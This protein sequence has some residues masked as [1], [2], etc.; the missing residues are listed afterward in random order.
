MDPFVW[1]GRALSSVEVFYDADHPSVYVHTRDP[2]VQ[3]SSV[4]NATQVLLLPSTQKVQGFTNLGSVTSGGGY[5]I[6]QPTMPAAISD[7][8]VRCCPP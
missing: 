2:D 3:V 5:W 1:H 6:Q 4:S 8:T 7:L